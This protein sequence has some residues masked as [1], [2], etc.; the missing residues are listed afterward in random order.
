[1]DESPNTQPVD[2][3]QQVF[4]IAGGYILS[5][6]LYVVAEAGVADHLAEGP[7]TSADLARATGTNE[8]ALYRMLRLL[9]GVGVFEE[10]SS[11]TFALTPS[12]DLLRKKHPRSI[13]DLIVFIA[14]PF[15]LNVYANLMESL[16]TGRPA[17][18]KTV[19]MPVFEYFGR[20]PEY[21]EIFNR[22]MTNL[23]AS[24]IPAAIE[25]YDFGGIGVLVDVAGGH[26][27]V[28]MSILRA[29]PAMRGVLM[30]LEHVIEGAKPRIAQAGLADRVQLVGGDFFKS[31]PAGDAYIM[32]HIIHDW[33]D[34]HAAQILRNIHT[35]MGERSGKV[36][37]L[38][39]VIRPGNVP[40]FG[41]I[42]DI[43]ML[44]LPGGRERTAEEFGALFKRAGFELTSI[45]P[46][47]SP[48]CVIEARRK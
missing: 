21:S 28:L 24:V 18:E 33:D 1:M 3:A 45:V 5:S 37:L 39:G 14:D 36:I 6:V 35:A 38:E 13:R 11:R 27:E 10:T 22:A 16:R 8:D 2:P 47:K 43:E 30:D 7:R 26:G 46:T 48:V 23:S 19:G 42:M 25:A 29:Y 32:K 15:H 9:S 4:Q 41:K 17:G 40:D 44:A 20:N 34:D 31:V 12:A